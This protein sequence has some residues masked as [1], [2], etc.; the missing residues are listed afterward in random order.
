M[1]AGS[2][3]GGVRDVERRI[4]EIL[5]TTTLVGESLAW[6]H[7][8][9]VRATLLDLAELLEASAP[10]PIDADTGDRS[11]RPVL[12]A[13]YRLGPCSPARLNECLPDG[14]ATVERLSA[15][16]RIEVV[17]SW[18]MIP[19]NRATRNWPAVISLLKVV[20]EE[21]AC[22]ARRIHHRVLADGAS[23]DDALAQAWDGLVGMVEVLV[24]LLANLSGYG[25]YIDKHDRNDDSG[26]TE[27]TDWT[28]TQLTS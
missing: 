19:L 20:Y 7:A 1:Y 11:I 9:A 6:R 5:A 2:F 14:E 16:D 13:R 21:V 8:I 28:I 10:I 26:T 27:F 24:N 12:D 4:D 17:D 3:L 23:E 22:D 15:D 25:Q 18:V